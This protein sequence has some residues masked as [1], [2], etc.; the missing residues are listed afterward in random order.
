MP[1]CTLLA[2]ALVALAAPA[3]AMPWERHP[4]LSFNATPMALD[5]AEGLDGDRTTSQFFGQLRRLGFACDAKDG[6]GR[7]IAVSCVSRSGS[8]RHRIKYTGQFIGAGYLGISQVSVDGIG[9]DKGARLRHIAEVYE[10]TDP[11]TSR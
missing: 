8:E 10:G 1:G 3:S 11:F 9:L 7:A 5:S 4:L 2:L 6:P